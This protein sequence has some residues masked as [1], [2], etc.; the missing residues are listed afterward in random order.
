M[1]PKRIAGTTHYLG[2]PKGWEPERDGDCSHLAVRQVG[3]CFES[4]WEPTPGELATLA[5]GGSIVLSCFGGQ[6]PVNLRVEP[7]P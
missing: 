4:A 5:A 6:P 7:A 3:V 2:A 1:I